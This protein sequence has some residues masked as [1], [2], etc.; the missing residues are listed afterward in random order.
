MVHHRGAS[1]LCG[2]GV[3]LQA[4]ELLSPTVTVALLQLLMTC[5]GDRGAL[6][7][8]FQETLSQSLSPITN[9]TETTQPQGLSTP[10]AVCGETSTSTPIFLLLV[11]EG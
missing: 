8:T 2:D 10:N 5:F 7:A 1:G 4:V 11:S 9:D 3:I 6:C